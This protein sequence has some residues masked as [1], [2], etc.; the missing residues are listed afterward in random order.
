MSVKMQYEILVQ[1]GVVA[2]GGKMENNRS[3]DFFVTAFNSTSVGDPGEIGV[4]MWVWCVL[5]VGVLAFGIGYLLGHKMGCCQPSVQPCLR[6]VEL[7]H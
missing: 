5:A 2:T 3:I 6:C 1:L 4:P 7:K